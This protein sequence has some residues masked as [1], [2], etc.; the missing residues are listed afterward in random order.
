METKVSYILT[1]IFVIVVTIATI[2]F[3]LWL[4][5]DVTISQYRPYVTYLDESVSG[6]YLNSPIKYRGVDVGKLRAMHLDPEN[7]TRVRLDMAIVADTPIRSD[8]IATL[9]QQGLTGIAY[10][11]LEGGA[12]GSPLISPLP[13]GEPAEIPSH[14]SLYNR[15]E[16]SLTRASLVFDQIG[17]RLIELLAPD[18][19]DAF[20]QTLQNLAALSETLRDHRQTLTSL[21]DNSADFA[22]NLAQSG[23]SLPALTTQFQALINRYQQL[24]KDLSKA[25]RTADRLGR[26]LEQATDHAEQDISTM[27]LGLEAEVRRLASEVASGAREVRLLT[28]KLNEN[29]NALIFGTT[30]PPP[31]PGE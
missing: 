18:N 15:L 16:D 20:S 25:A 10:V 2:G 1:G 29:P 7:P 24:G 14:P 23:A 9:A 26:R 28:R 22:Q 17:A 31:G 12:Q 27:T 30:P 19:V 3:G 13:N 8:T 11:E 4:G 5:S 21:L 6:L